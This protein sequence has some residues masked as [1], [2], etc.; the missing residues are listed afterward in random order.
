VLIKSK[1][2]LR[3]KG[4]S[5]IEINKKISSEAAIYTVVA[6]LIFVIFGQLTTVFREHT[7][8]PEEEQY[9]I[10]VEND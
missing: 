8:L 1:E 2:T 4:Y 7:K 6:M 10:R 5:Q 9:I 3:F